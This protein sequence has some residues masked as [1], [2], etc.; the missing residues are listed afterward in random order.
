MGAGSAG[1]RALIL[2]EVK[3]LAQKTGKSPGVAV[4]TQETGIAQHEWLGVFWARWSDVLAEAGLEANELQAKYDTQSVLRQV[5][6]AS[7]QLGRVPTFHEMKM[8]RRNGVALPNP[9][10]ISAHF[11]SKDLMLEALRSLA[12]DPDYVELTDLLPKS[13]VE[14]EQGLQAKPDGWI[15]LLKSGSYYKIGRSDSI[16]RRIK[17]IGVALPEAVTLVH[18][19]HT[20]DQVGIEAYWHKRFAALRLNGEWFKLGRQEIAAFKRRKFQ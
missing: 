10:T 14:D 18:S 16:E 11:G 17:E 2:A 4:F 20:D 3:R 5:A 12:I 6:D 9:K 1:L 15:Y 7:L 8:L 13:V 19:I